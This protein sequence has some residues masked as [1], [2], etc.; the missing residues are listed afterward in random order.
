MHT[1]VAY[2]LSLV[3]DSFESNRKYWETHVDA[4]EAQ[5]FQQSIQTLHREQQ[6]ELRSWNEQM[7]R[8][9][10]LNRR[11]DRVLH[12]ST[13][14]SMHSD[15]KTV[16]SHPKENNSER[17]ETASKEELTSTYLIDYAD[18]HFDQ[19][20][21]QSTK[22]IKPTIKTTTGFFLAKQLLKRAQDTLHSIVQINLIGY[23]ITELMMIS[24]LIFYLINKKRNQ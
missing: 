8:L 20:R 15:S 16:T 11:I 12:R 1:T 7:N 3:M 21:D 14:E 19:V 18:F 9:N 13:D 6:R 24:S 17:L 22:P 5:S 2:V 10:A 23:N 4:F